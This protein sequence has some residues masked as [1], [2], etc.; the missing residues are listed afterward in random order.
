MP[1][2]QEVITELQNTATELMQVLEAFTQEQLNNIPFEGSWTAAQVAQHILLSNS[3][4]LQ[5]SRVKEK[6]VEREPVKELRN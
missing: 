4:I 2:T 1:V 3:F 5:S 6:T